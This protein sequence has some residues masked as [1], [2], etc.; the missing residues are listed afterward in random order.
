[1]KINSLYPV[2]C[3][4]KIAESKEFYTTHFPLTITFESDWYVSLRTRDE[5]A[6]E[7]ALL[8]A[9]HPTIPKEFRAS[10]QT[11]LIINIEVDEVD[12]VYDAFC[13]AGL[14]IQLSLRSEDFGQRHFI[15][16]DPN[17]I[18][19]DIIKVIAPSGEFIEG[20]SEE[21]QQRMSAGQG[22]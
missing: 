3:T 17:G 7:L 13:A 1:M 20:F 2:I 5:P 6:F 21:E 11:G 4:Q 16:T 9:S 14:P 19:L 22:E 12:S 15:T 18:L 10:Y 8:D